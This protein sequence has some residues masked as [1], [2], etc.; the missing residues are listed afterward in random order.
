MVKQ[1][2]A[3]I[4]M[5]QPLEEVMIST[6]QIMQIPIITLT[7]IAIRI[8]VPI[9]IIISGPE[10][11]TSTQRRWKF[12]MKCLLKFDYLEKYK[13]ISHFMYWVNSYHWLNWRSLN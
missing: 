6:L 7:V 2:T 3:T 4:T 10:V 9:V 11:S 13:K 5:V 8:V 1:H 12:T